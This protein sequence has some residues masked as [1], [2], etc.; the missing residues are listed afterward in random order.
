MTGGWGSVLAAMKNPKNLLNLGSM[1]S[2]GSQASANNRGAEIE[3][4]LAQEAIRNSEG[5]G[6]NADVIN[7]DQANMEAQSDAWKKYLAS[8]Y[9]QN[10]KPTPG[11]S[12]YTRAIAPP[13]ADTVAAA[14]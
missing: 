4:L 3:A 2:K 8:Q 7:R 14:G 11:V 12:P 6:Y 10:W 5:R 1:F 9:V 13:S